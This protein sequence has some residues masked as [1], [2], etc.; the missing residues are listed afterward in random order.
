[1]EGRA[2]TILELLLAIIS[3]LEEEVILE[4]FEDHEEQ[5]RFEGGGNVSV[6]KHT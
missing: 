1:M 4:H 3:F 6:Y 5:R 2:V